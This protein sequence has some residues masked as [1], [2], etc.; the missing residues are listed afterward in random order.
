MKYP[1]LALL[2]IT[3]TLAFPALLAA[4]SSALIISGVPGDDEHAQRFQKWTDTTQKILV[5]K[6]GFS[7]D[8][9]VVLADK[10]SA[11]DEIR[12]AFAQIREQIKPG[13]TFFLFMIGHGSYEDSY[14]F[15]I[16]G[17]DLTAEDY[18]KLISTL[19]AS[20]VVI[21]NATSASGGSIDALSGKNR[22]VITATKSGMEGNETMFYQYFLAALQSPEADEDKDQK[23]SVWEAF[24]YA[25]NEVDRYYK[26][27]GRLMTEHAEISDNGT[28]KV[29]AAAK[30]PP[31]LARITTFQVEK[32][33]T[34]SDPKLQALMNEKAALEKKI[35]DLRVN[36]AS[37][38]EAQYEKQ[39]EDLIIQLATKNQ[40]I[41]GK[42]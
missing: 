12:K 29:T 39:M 33:V 30:E 14:K 21:V 9:V 11:A 5:E 7:P 17:P 34:V 23:I 40:E 8:H 4:N 32:T 24:K 38:P 13:D 41:K 22:V 27:E 35:D 37:M 2:L 16:F 15:N 20:R 6:F 28:E 18:N 3:L 10:K 26:D 31:P 25:A 36:K 1:R 42:P 19:N